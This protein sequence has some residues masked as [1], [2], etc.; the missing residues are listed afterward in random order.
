M[1]AC[2]KD[3]TVFTILML[4]EDSTEA[5]YRPAC[6]QFCDT[7]K[8]RKTEVEALRPAAVKS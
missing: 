3:P 7:C 2:H 6:R 5:Q 1:P 4:K 8:D